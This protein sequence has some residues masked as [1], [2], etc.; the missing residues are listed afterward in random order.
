[1]LEH[2][3]KMCPYCKS[4]ISQLDKIIV[5]SEC[6]MPHHEECY[7]ENGGCTTFGCANSSD[8]HGTVNDN[9]ENTYAYNEDGDMDTLALKVFDRKYFSTFIG[10][11][12]HHYFGAFERFKSGSKS[13]FN[14]CA[15][16][17]SI[18]WMMFR[19]LYIEAAILFLIHMCLG[20]LLGLVLSILGGFFGNYIYFMKYKRVLGQTEYMSEE[21]RMQHLEKKGGT[22]GT[23]VL[24]YFAVSIILAF[25]RVAYL[26]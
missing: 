22:N 8:N 17:F 25:I 24:I 21:E 4:T 11:D 14:W 1:M 15:L 2:V 13:Y 7:V 3:G 18:P 5:C 19:K 6:N 16:L 20:S 9:S 10:G 12:D 26:M 23:A